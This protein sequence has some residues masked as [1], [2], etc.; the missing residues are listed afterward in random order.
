[1]H[2][3]GAPFFQTMFIDRVHLLVQAGHGGK[4]CESYFR[5]TDKKLVPH[6]GDGGKGGG[7]IFRADVNAPGL[8]SFR[9]RQHLI[10]E[11][12]G[13]GGSNRK[14]G[15]NGKDLVVLVPP[16]IRIHDRV[17][18]L[19]I[20]R[21]AHAGEEVIILEGGKGGVG[22]CGGKQATPGERGK[23]LD[24]ELD[25]RIAADVFLVGLPNSGK[26][27]L[28]NRL[29]HTHF[30]EED[31][32]FA[33]RNPEVVV[34]DIEE[35]ENGAKLVLCELPSLYHASHEGRGRGTDFLKHL[36]G[37]KCIFYLLDPVSKFC[38]SLKEGLAIL[39]KE[40]EIYQKDFLQIPQG[41]IVN[42]MDLA[43]AQEKV[44]QENFKPR[45][46][47]FFIS[48]LTGTGL[49]E[50]SAYLKRYVPDIENDAAEFKTR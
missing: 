7:V 14:R 17:R 1:M 15:K 24:L 27:K 20:R 40:I 5:R 11:S 36:E 9:Y 21:L 49:A 10:A 31:Y 38:S 4:G 26:S 16:G 30:K 45:A 39:K 19:L 34:W 3:R 41:I 6:G 32:P 37:A 8:G 43:E 13:H 12:G 44:K 47:V 33:T 22:N 50:L 2:T 18:N 28:L 42:K 48:A 29:A 46:P 35:E 23:S 25:I